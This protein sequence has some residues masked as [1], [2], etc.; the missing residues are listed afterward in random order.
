MIYIVNGGGKV[1]ENEKLNK[2]TAGM[3]IIKRIGSL[4]ITRTFGTQ[5]YN[6]TGDIYLTAELLGHEDIN[7]TKK[8][9]ASM[10]NEKLKRA[11]DIIKLD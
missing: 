3:L 11:A 7:T 6:N 8:H 10:D 1:Y 5:I 9:Y 4:L 2:V